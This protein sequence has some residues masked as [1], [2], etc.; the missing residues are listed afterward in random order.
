MGELT[1]RIVPPLADCVED[2]VA[3]GRY[4]SVEEA[5]N[6]ALM[7][8]QDEYL[9]TPEQTAAL[10]LR[11]QQAMGEITAGEVVDWDPDEIMREVDRRLASK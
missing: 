8:L 9:E 5:V 3:K 10:K 7:R 11:V 2:L 6:D 1:V 4:G